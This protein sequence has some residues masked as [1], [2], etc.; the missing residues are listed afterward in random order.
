MEGGHN[1]SL[2]TF[3]SGLVD[4]IREIPVVF[5]R[6]ESNE[7]TGLSKRETDD[8]GYAGP[9]RENNRKKANV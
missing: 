5:S 7:L 8:S 3:R 2:T 4:G 1:L 6:I 9:I